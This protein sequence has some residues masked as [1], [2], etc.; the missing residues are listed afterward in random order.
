MFTLNEIIRGITG[1]NGL[2][3]DISFTDAAIDSRAVTEGMLFAAVP[4]ERTDGHQFLDSAFSNGAS[5]ALVQEDVSDRF[6]CLDLREGHI[7]DAA[8]AEWSG[9][10]PLCIRVENTVEALQKTAAFHRRQLSGMNVVGVTGTVGK[11]TTK[12]MIY[13]VISQHYKTLK[14]AGN[15]NNEIGLPLTLLRAENDTEQ[16]ILE[17]GFYVPGEIDQLCQIALPS[18]GVITNVGMVHAARAGSMEIIAQGKSELVRALP[19]GGTA[20]LNYDDPYV[21]PMAELTKAKVLYYGLDPKADLWADDIKGLGLDGVQFTLNYEGRRHPV[22]IPAIGTHSVLTALRGTTVG[23]VLGLSW[24]EIT[25]ALETSRTQLRMRITHAAG[26]GLI[27]DDTYN[28]SPESTLAALNLLSEIKGRKIAALGDMLELGQY[29]Q[30]GHE[31]VGKRA[32]EVC[33]ELITVGPLSNYTADSAAA[34]GLPVQKIHRFEN[35]E[36]AAVFMKDIYGKEDEVLLVKG[37]RGM[38][39]ERII[40]RLED[41]E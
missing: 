15:R 38:T 28:A 29:E 20:I 30:K 23:L 25:A 33:D 8:A 3:R 16:A 31:M 22:K 18:V 19:D 21:R 37:S 5:A 35:S 11:T 10:K 27:I 26:K 13:D 12:E 32:A 7:D 9:E 17:M 14:T 24:D 36:E 40:E 4:G 6:F 34:H 41:R 1:N 2:T 39:M